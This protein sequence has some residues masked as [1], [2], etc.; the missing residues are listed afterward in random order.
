MSKKNKE[1]IRI[2][3]KKPRNSY[4]DTEEEEE[5][6]ETAKRLK[7]LKEQDES[8]LKKQN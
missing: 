4:L 7:L 5:M 1:N 8:E 6:I 3:T 2:T